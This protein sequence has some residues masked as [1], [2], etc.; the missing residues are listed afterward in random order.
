MDPYRIQNVLDVLLASE[1]ANL[2]EW[3]EAINTLN[4]LINTAGLYKIDN[5]PEKVADTLLDKMQ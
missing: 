5:N 1:P 3:Q 2:S 4:E